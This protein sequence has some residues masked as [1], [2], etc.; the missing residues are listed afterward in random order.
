MRIQIREL[1]LKILILFPIFTL[2]AF[3]SEATTILSLLGAVGMICILIQ[4]GVKRTC[5]FILVSVTLLTIWN[6]SITAE[7]VIN[8]NE[9]IYFEY[10]CV[11]TAFLVS[12]KHLLN[13]YLQHDKRYIKIICRIW[14]FIVVG[15]MFLSSSYQRGVFVSFAVTTF[16]LSPSAIL[17]MALSSVLIASEG[18]SKNLIYTFIPLLAILMGS[19]RTYLVIGTLMLLINLSMI[20]K[21]KSTFVLLVVVL[22]LSGLAIVN[23][24]AMGDKFTSSITEQAYRDSLGVFTSGRSNFWAKDIKAFK[25]QAPINRLLGCG[26]NFIRI[27]NGAIPGTNAKGIWAHNDFIQIVITYGFTGL[28]LYLINMY[29]MFRELI[30]SKTPLLVGLSVFLI[31]FFNAM[32]N[33]YF[34]YTCSMIAL[35]ITFMACD[36]YK[37]EH[38]KWFTK[39]D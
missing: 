1:T 32:F 13:D 3:V 20:V 33:M 18:S 16:R 24:S 22:L 39:E 21:K 34:T 36:I 7:K 17:I 4:S 15:S 38:L 6:Y 35:P 10:L 31:W 12:N 8:T 30:N 27:T 19:S 25:E 2:L 5:F 28:F 37:K 23:N 11:F 29:I 26:Y 14:C 9:I